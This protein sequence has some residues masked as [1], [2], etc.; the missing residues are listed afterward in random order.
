MIRPRV[1]IAS[2]HDI[3]HDAGLMTILKRLLWPFTQRDLFAGLAAFVI[4]LAVYI[5]TAAPNVTLLD[6][7][8]FVTAAYHMGV[9]H[10]TGYPLW[11]IGAWL[12]TH[13]PFGSVAW[14]VSV[15]SGFCGALAVGLAAIL[16]S[17]MMRWIGR[18]I[19]QSNAQLACRV[20]LQLRKFSPIAA[21]ILSLCLAFSESMWSQC[22][23]AEVYA[24]HALI[25]LLM[26]TALYRW[27]LRPSHLGAWVTAI[28][29]FA[30]GMSNHHLMISL[31]PVFLI[32]LLLRRRDLILEFGVYLGF[33]AALLYL[34]FAWLSDDPTT[35]YVDSPV[36]WRASIRLIW[37][38]ATGL[39]IYGIWK[40]GLPYWRQG[41]AMLAVIVLGLLPYAYMPLASS[42]NPPM[43]WSYT[44]LKPGFFYAINRSQYQGT[45]SSQLEGTIGKA[46]GAA[47]P[48]A[49]L[50]RT[51][52]Q[53]M[54]ETVLFQKVPPFIGFYWSKIVHSFSPFIIVLLVLTFLSLL[55]LPFKQRVWVLALYVAFFLAAF[56]QPIFDKP[57]IDVSG[58]GLQMP[59]HTYSFALCVVT[60]AIGTSVLFILLSKKLP[61]WT[62]II[63]ISWLPIYGFV[64]NYAQTSQRNHWFGWR[65]GHDM[66]QDLPR[67]SVFYGGTDPGRF[68]PT[69]MIFCES[70]MEPKYRK[71][72]TFDRRDLYIITQNALADV[73][74]NRYIRS[75]Y[76]NERPQLTRWIE[77]WLGREMA[78]PK[79][80]LVIPNR[81]DVQEMVLQAI[82][83]A[84]AKAPL[85]VV[86]Q[87]YLANSVVAEWIFL[88]NRDKHDFFVEESF[89][90]EWS[91][92]YAVPHGL[93]MKLMHEKLDRIPDELVQKD[94]V[95]WK[96]Y[97]NQL[98]KDPFFQDDID[99]QKSFSK[100]RTSIGNLYKFRQLLKEAEIAYREALELC[101]S[102]AE[103]LNPLDAMLCDQKRYDEALALTK[104]G[105]KEDLYNSGLLQLLNIIQ[106][107]QQANATV[108]Q[109]KGEWERHPQSSGIA[110]TLVQAYATMG[111]LKHADE[112]VEVVLKNHLTDGVLYTEFLNYYMQTMRL[113]KA[114]NLAKSWTNAC[115][116]EPEAWW[117]FARLTW[118]LQDKKASFQAAARAVQLGGLAMRNR[119]ETSPEFQAAWNELEFNQAMEFDKKDLK[120]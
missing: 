30:L 105:L 33:I 15:Y 2:R 70:F 11:T 78:Y 80:Y 21:V 117:N 62:G 18:G 76:S 20:K 109:L 37:C 17:H 54:P 43:N 99:A 28:F 42:T 103:A 24:L 40:K 83:P 9:P 56:L 77:K 95:F 98:M 60:A 79:E 75:H 119:F 8:E 3:V 89:P 52:Q 22:T 86:D 111:D 118:L 31:S 19:G 29:F 102:N 44:S 57:S 48:E 114:L 6:S 34:G 4:S 96:N 59:Y 92:P 120:K 67:G 63:V 69:Y 16:M 23:I 113:D 35:P 10:P 45:L 25:V 107:H 82:V 115:K 50:S 12:F 39:V 13:L 14:R 97:K 85:N 61:W 74:Y 49:Y 91:Y 110:R 1:C 81:E 101:P 36:T 104:R 68:V 88:R 106:T 94:L 27:N 87:T 38:A 90:M 65:Y 5:Y 32:L 66:L 71:D 64:H 55:F 116:N 93:C 26:I 51:G 108:V 73:F 58:W 112:V 84:S 46:M 72:P 47:S 100:L 7:G 53:Q 41:V